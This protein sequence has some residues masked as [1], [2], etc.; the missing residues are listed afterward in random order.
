MVAHSVTRTLRWMGLSGVLILAGCGG[1][2]PEMGSVKGTV[3][4]DGKPVQGARLEFHPQEGH[5]PPSY[6]LT[7]EDGYYSASFSDTLDGVYLGP[8]LVQVWMDDVTMVDGQPV[9]EEFP[10]RYNRDTELKRTVDAGTNT[11]DFDLTSNK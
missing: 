1:A 4:L 6:G 9:Q 3:K 8:V 2:G 7:D 10:T 11:F 5:K